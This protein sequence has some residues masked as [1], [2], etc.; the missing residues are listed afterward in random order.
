MANKG[1]TGT[2]KQY[3]EGLASGLRVARGTT[4]SILEDVRSRFVPASV[5]PGPVATPAS[6][7]LPEPKPA[8]EIAR[9]A[10]DSA[11]VRQ[12]TLP[13]PPLD[14]PAHPDQ[15]MWDAQNRTLQAGQ[16][17]S[18]EERVK[19]RQPPHEL[20]QRMQRLARE[21]RFPLGDDRFLFKFHGLFYVSP[22]EEAFMC[23][24][25]FAGGRVLA[26]QLRGVADLAAR[27]G[28]PSVQLTTRSNLQLRG[29]GAE[30][31]LEV[32]SG[33]LELGIV[34]QGSGG[35]G[36]RNVGASP[37]AGFDRREL[38]DTLPLAK[39]AQHRILNE[40]ALGGLPRKFTLGFDGG[41]SVSALA[42]ACDLGFRAVSVPPGERVA[43][44]VY[45]RL[46]LGGAT[47]HARYGRD[48]GVV[49]APEQCL[50]VMEQVLRLY[51]EH[52]DRTNRRRARLA[53]LLET[54]GMPRFVAELQERLGPPSALRRAESSRPALA[55]SELPLA[56]LPL[57][58]CVLPA[59]PDPFA[60]IGFHNQKPRGFSYVGVVL[61]GAQLSVA[62]AR[63]LAAIADEQGS[64]ELRLTPH[65]NIIVPGL[66]DTQL[67]RAKEALDKLGLAWTA[68]AFRSRL[69]ACTGSPGCP[70]AMSDTKRRGDEL[71]RHLEASN[72]LEQPLSIHISGCHHACAQHTT[73]DIGLLATRDPAAPEAAERYQVWLGG[74]L[75]D[76]AHFGRQYAAAVPA[77]EVSRLV[78]EV[79]D[80][81]LTERLPDETFREF[82]GR[83]PPRA[84][85]RWS[86]ERGSDAGV[87]P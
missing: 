10:A 81:Y 64:G 42:E 29:I 25:R 63:G 33:L 38:I 48:A 74:E 30:A 87:V 70:F 86:P 6:G 77:S 47:S 14:A 56:E 52:G 1:F 82:V 75:S 28:Q 4:R 39:R 41:A 15:A 23:R 44:G 65:Q 49:V 58:R 36:V 59:H 35:D 71:V 62:Q 43:P 69:V 34:N 55:L 73:A 84:C 53:Y 12:Q 40:R 27:F 7:S 54:W 45:F 26:H 21:R 2:Q 16:R 13:S 85:E 60:H 67:Q 3:L 19:R 80:A 17:L 51:I 5:A 78:Q 61:D 20:W 37:T 50:D 79:V 66:K 9:V 22:A 76:T 31:G 46:L 57:E 8:R 72:A 83:V 24:L 32:L 18:P 11:A 68:S